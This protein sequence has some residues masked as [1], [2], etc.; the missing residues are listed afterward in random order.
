MT[1]APGPQAFDDFYEAL[2]TY[3]ECDR[4]ALDTAHGMACRM[5][6]PKEF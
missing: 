4:H 5:R 6:R 2:D 1:H 3:W